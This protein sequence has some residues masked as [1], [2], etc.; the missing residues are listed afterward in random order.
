VIDPTSSLEQLAA[1]IGAQR[2]SGGSRPTFANIHGR[3][4]AKVYASD[5]RLDKFIDTATL[6]HAK[7]LP[8]PSGTPQTVLLTGAN[9]YLGR[10]L[11]LE[12]LEKLAPAGG[13]LIC[14]TRGGSTTAARQRIDD[15]LA[16]DR[17]LAERFQ[18]LA[19]AHLEVLAG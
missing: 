17:E 14:V 15:A 9:G 7:C 13:T 12:W 16:G 3:H 18:R 4:S 19:G 8:Q 2:R 10:F 6:E 11:C 5:L 1:C